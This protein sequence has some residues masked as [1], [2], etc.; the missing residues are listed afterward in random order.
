MDLLFSENAQLHFTTREKFFFFEKP[1]RE[2]FLLFRKKPVHVPA[3]APVGT[4]GKRRKRS[5]AENMSNCHKVS[6][7]ECRMVGKKSWE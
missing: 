1:L 4:P 6:G 5:L 7:D 3:A 2:K